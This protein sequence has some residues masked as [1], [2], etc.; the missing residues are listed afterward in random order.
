MKKSGFLFIVI[1]AL[2]FS[3]MNAQTLKEKEQERQNNKVKLFSDA[4]FANL[5]LWFIE[6]V[7]KM[8]MSE[9]V[10]MEYSSI[11]NMR[12]NKMSRLDDKD[13]G[14]SKEE[15]ITKFN[16]ELTNL[17][18]DVKPILDDRQYGQHLEIMEVASKAIIDKL[19]LKD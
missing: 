1:F 5:N 2:S 17:N 8:N 3:N 15:M 12:L 9:K 7:Q 4:E 14:F 6:E 16:E 19:K 10:E 11:L 18:A 13:K